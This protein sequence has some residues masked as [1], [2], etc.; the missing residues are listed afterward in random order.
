ML[1]LI[2]KLMMDVDMIWVVPKVKDL[3][4]PPGEPIESIEIVIFRET[5]LI[6]VRSTS[7]TTSSTSFWIPPYSVL[8]QRPAHPRSHG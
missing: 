7:W 3:E 2:G 6:E 1:S 8:R 5:Y 4:Y